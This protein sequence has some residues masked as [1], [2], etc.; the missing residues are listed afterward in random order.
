MLLALISSAN[1]TVSS[2]VNF[3]K[4]SGFIGFR[5]KPC[6]NSFVFIAGESNTARTSLFKN[7]ITAAKV[8]AGANT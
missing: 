1:F 8:A 3:L 7:E 5:V 2:L 4:L 6:A